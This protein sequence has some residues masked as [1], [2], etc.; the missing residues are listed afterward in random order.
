MNRNEAVAASNLVSSATMAAL[1][2][3]LLHKGVLNPADVR[4]LYETALLMLEQ[5]QGM[6]PKGQEAFLA[7][8]AVIERNLQA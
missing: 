8:R 1:L 4:E 7:A 2:R 3:C 5:Q 6:T